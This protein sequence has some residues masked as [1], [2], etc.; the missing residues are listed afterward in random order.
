MNRAIPIAL[1]S[2]LAT[3]ACSHDVRRFPLAPPVWTDPDRDAV[4]ERPEELYSGLMADG[5]DKMLLYGAARTWRFELPEEAKNVNALDEVPN[6]SW[7]QNR[8]GLFD[9]T[10][11]EAGKG[12]CI[13]GPTLDPSKGPWTVTAAKPNGANPGFFIKAADGTRYLL[14]F[15][16]PQQPTRATGSDVMG[17]KIYWAAGFHTPCN[18][19]VYF[20]ESILK[21][22]PEAESENEYGEDVPMS[23]EA[24]NK[25]L[26]KA[27]RLKNGLLRASASRFVPG[28]PIG[29]FRYEDTD[30]GDPNDVI[31]HEDRRELRASQVLASWINHFDSREQNTLRVWME[32]PSGKGG[33][34][35]HYFIDWGDSLGGRWPFDGISRRLGHSYYFD[36]WDVLG[37]LVTLGLIPRP[38]NKVKLNDYDIFGYLDA[39]TFKS[40]AW[41]GGYPNPAH[42]RMTPTDA[43]W[44]VRIMSRMTPAHIRAMVQASKFPDPRYEEFILQRLLERR[45]KI[46]EEY[47]TEYAPL[48]FFQVARRRQ[49]DLQQSLCFEDLALRHKVANPELTRYH[50]RFYGG[51]KLDEELGWLQF[52]PDAEHPH[53]SCTV[54]PIGY[55]RPA[56]LAPEGAPDDH[57]LRYGRL[58][59]FV[60]Q[61]K[62]V[63]PQSSMRLYFYDL[64]PE[65][66]FQLVGIERPQ[67]PIVPGKY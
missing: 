5:L 25:V 30:E 53:R 9:M 7:F 54:L 20:P 46:F 33:Y 67:R 64:G 34:V 52:S 49:G 11:E 38:W 48:A 23:D 37:D 1:I 12:P 39:K 13:D 44:M 6:S 55:Q 27:F 41:K 58:D 51:S 14:K 47:L 21:I 8:I 57:P 65:R 35:E 26:V 45:Q 4:A 15:D 10:P 16:G 32:H 60:H 29:P 19:V 50:M 2:A 62:T 43:L 63:R 56:D 24:I 18:H 28:R 61:K 59:I 17:S 42:D 40:S 22:D 3:S 66:G 31:P 36:K